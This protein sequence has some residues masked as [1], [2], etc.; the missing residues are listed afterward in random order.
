VIYLVGGW[1][2]GDIIALLVGGREGVSMGSSGCRCY[3]WIEGGYC[4]K[5]DSNIAL[6]ESVYCSL[7][8]FPDFTVVYMWNCSR[9]FNVLPFR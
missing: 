2:G 1:G 9:V 7:R 3:C 8:W 6:W 5:M 4:F